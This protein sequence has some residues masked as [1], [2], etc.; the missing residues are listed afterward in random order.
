MMSEPVRL[1]VASDAATLAVTGATFEEFFER[2]A[3]FGR[4]MRPRRA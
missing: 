1:T 4:E 2:E 3:E